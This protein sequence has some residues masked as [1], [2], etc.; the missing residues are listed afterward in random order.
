[1]NPK[2]NSTL[3][4]SASDETAWVNP[5]SS[6]RYNLVIIGAGPAGLTCA[7]AAAKLGAKVALIERESMGGDCLNVGCVP[8]K[9]LIR[10][11][12]LS[13]E[14]LRS[15]SFGLATAG[16]APTPDDFDAAMQR[17]R[18]LR[19]RIGRHD[20][21][22]RFSD[23]GVDVF[24]GHARFLNRHTI[25]VAGQEL[26]FKKAV[27][28]TGARAAKPNIPGIDDAGYCTN[29]NIFD[30]TIRPKRLG[31]IGGGPLGCELSQAFRRLG[32]EVAIV[33]KTPL[34]LPKEERDAAQI[35]SD[36]LTADGVQVHLN[37][38]V[39]KVSVN[40]KAKVLHVRRGSDTFT[41][42]VDEILAGIGR[43]PNVEDLGLE[44][45]GIDWEPGKGI[46]VDDFLRTRNRAVYAAGD[47]CMAEK[48]THVADATARI[49]IRN[50]LFGGR[51][52]HSTLLIPWCTYT[53]PEIAHVGV[54]VR[55]ANAEK[56][57]IK[58]FTVLLSDVD[59]AV[60]DGEERGFVKIHTEDGTDRILGATIVARHA[61]E[62]INEISLAMVSGIGLKTLS[63]V[64]HAYPT[65]AEAIKMAADAFTATRLTPSLQRFTKLWLRWSR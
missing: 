63:K 14:R 18:H 4:E 53:D 50:A 12:Q 51:E 28:A 31:V 48:F 20:S 42:E 40:G 24:K 46:V 27:I 43:L 47:A 58:T 49:V 36:A 55:H 23:L 54:Y 39:E 25:G 2:A 3:E 62:M 19:A 38:V 29:E 9:A 8:S 61:G 7:V 21:V 56:F 35:L 13:A 16:P 60:L 6:G 45:A 22:E 44:A 15:P 33:H 65:Q 5:I 30:L 34:F 26:V 41:I 57:R 11:G 37:A 32:C 1:M 64:I 52:R 10:S 17:M 59:R